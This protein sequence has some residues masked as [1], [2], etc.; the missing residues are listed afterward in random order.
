MA[1]IETIKI[2]GDASEFNKA[3]EE[4]NT[5][6]ES[7]DTQLTRANTE[8]KEFGDKGEKAI[9]GVKQEVKETG[10]GLKDLIKNLGGLAII[11]KLGDAASEAFTGNQKVVDT[12]NTGLFTAQLAVSGLIEYLTGSKGLSEAFGSIFQ[13]AKD[14][15]RLQKESQL[16][17]VT[18]TELQ[19]IGQKLAEEQ[20][21]IRDEER[22]SLTKRIQAN[23]KINEILNDQLA[24]EK[25]TVN[26]K[27]AAAQ[28]EVNKLPNLEN[29]IAL[30]QANIELLDIEERILG[31]KSEY[32]S[33]DLALTRESLEIAQL[34]AE[35]EIERF[36]FEK[37]MNQED[38]LVSNQNQLKKLQV[39]KY[40]D[41]QIY[42]L[43]VAALDK[44]LELYDKDSVAYQQAVNDKLALEREYVL[45]RQQTE[46]EISSLNYEANQ[47]RL[48]MVKDTF[49]AIGNLSA[50]F[51]GEDEESKRQQFELQ[52]KLSLASAIVSGILAVQNAYKTAQGSPYTLLNP[53]YPFIQAGLAG[54]FAAAQV[55]S[56][57]KTQFDSQDASSLTTSTSSPSQPAQ[58]NI[59]GQSGTNQL[60]EGLAGQFDKPI[61]AYVVSGEVISGSELDRRRLRTATFP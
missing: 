60:V 52:K 56:I 22:N 35:Q 31:Q 27:I 5:R 7:L 36:E 44:T 43:K 39:Q 16:A 1:T 2:E 33:N 49:T 6:I 32:L 51:A 13:D 59:V 61:R 58:F 9:K 48:G 10:K 57:A 55:A 41:E 25:E 46:N 28:A 54:A 11:S 26:I 42:Q 53:A 24:G 17:E 30:R 12:M 19:F 4:L 23:E 14:L 15:V 34:R 50:A 21:Q 45:N 20:R 37:T 3:L 47:Q 18:R 29:E 38:L 40:F 8:I